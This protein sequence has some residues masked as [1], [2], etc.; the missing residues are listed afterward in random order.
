VRVADVWSMRL[1]P[2]FLLLATALPAWPQSQTVVT[3]HEGETITL[4][5]SPQPQPED[6]TFWSS[7]TSDAPLRTNREAFH[8]KAW[9]TTQIVWLGA[10]IYDSELTH[11]GLAHHNCVEGNPLLSQHPS[12]SALY[13]SDLPEYGV[14]TV[15]NYLALRFI[16]KPLIFEFAGVGTVKHLIGGSSWLTRCW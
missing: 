14:G 5:E 12:R 6:A 3:V 2:F 9:R 8:D 7:G 13:L 16:G 4:P 11:Q 10:I 15:F 1:F